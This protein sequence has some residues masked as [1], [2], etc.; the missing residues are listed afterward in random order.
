[1]KRPAADEDTGRSMG[2]TLRT[3]GFIV[4]YWPTPSTTHEAVVNAGL[5]VAAH[6]RG[7]LSITPIVRGGGGYHSLSCRE[8]HYKVGH[9]SY[10][11]Q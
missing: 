2:T 3:S 10:T 7:D 9:S 6:A 1:M 11:Q 5:L 4:V 8:E